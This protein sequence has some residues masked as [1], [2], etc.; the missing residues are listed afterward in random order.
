MADTLFNLPDSP[1]E[2]GVVL[3]PAD[4]RRIDFS[5]LDFPTL[6]RVVIEYIKTYYPDRFNDFS[7][8]NGIIMLTEI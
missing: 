8:N 2:F 1:E 6:R 5:A 3:P 4:L 7:T